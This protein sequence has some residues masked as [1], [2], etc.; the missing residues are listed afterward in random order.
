ML[1]DEVR[2]LGDVAGVEVGDA[3]IQ[4]D[5][6]YISEVEDGEIE[7]VGLC[8]NGI[9]HANFNAKNPQRLDNDVEQQHPKKTGD[10]FF[11]QKMEIRSFED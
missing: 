10:E 8:S 6:E 11:V 5:V 1:A 2:V 9:L 3:Q 4:Q 7:S